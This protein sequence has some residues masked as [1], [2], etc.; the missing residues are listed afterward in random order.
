MSDTTTKTKEVTTTVI[1][2]PGKYKV[3]VCNDDV[4]PMEFVI[5]MLMTIFKHKQDSATDLT[6]KIHNDGRAIAGVYTYE[7]AEQKG[8]DATSLSREHGYPLVIKVEE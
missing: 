8:I 1:K 4:T 2:E 3:V 5:V 6:L 7:I